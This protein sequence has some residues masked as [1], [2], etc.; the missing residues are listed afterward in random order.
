MLGLDWAAATASGGTLGTLAR[1]LALSYAIG[2][3]LNAAFW[4]LFGNEP[5]VR[6]SSWRVLGSG[7]P[8]RQSLAPYFRVAALLGGPGLALVPIGSAICS[9]HR[10]AP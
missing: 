10:P 3:V 9:G 2:L 6:A 4:A 5:K 7:G 1:E 8:G